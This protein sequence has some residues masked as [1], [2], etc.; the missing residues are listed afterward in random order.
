MKAITFNMFL[1]LFVAIVGASLSLYL[2]SQVVHAPIASY[3]QSTFTGCGRSGQDCCLN[4][5]CNVGLLCSNSICIENQS[6]TIMIDE[7][8]LIY[9]AS[10]TLNSTQRDEYLYGKAGLGLEDCSNGVNCISCSKIFNFTNSS[11]CLDCSLCDSHDK[12]CKD[13]LSCNSAENGNY[14]DLYECYNCNNCNNIQYD[15]ADSCSHCEYC[16]MAN[17]TNPSAPSNASFCSSCYQCEPGTSDKCYSCYDCDASKE[18]VCGVCDKSPQTTCKVQ[19]DYELCKELKKHIVSYYNEQTHEVEELLSIPWNEAYF[20]NTTIS[21]VLTNCITEDLKGMLPGN[22]QQK[23]CKYDSSKI[24]FIQNDTWLPVSVIIEPFSLGSVLVRSYFFNDVSYVPP[25]N[26]ANMLTLN[27]QY[28]SVTGENKGI[29]FN[30]CGVKTTPELI[31][32]FNWQPEI[33]YSSNPEIFSSSTAP[34]TPEGDIPVNLKIV[35]ADVSWNEQYDNGCSFNVYLCPQ[36]AIATSGDDTILNFYRFLAYFNESDYSVKTKT[37]NKVYKMGPLNDVLEVNVTGIKYPAFVVDLGGRNADVAHIAKALIAGFR[38]Y[39]A[40]NSDLNQTVKFF[41]EES[42]LNFEDCYKNSFSVVINDNVPWNLSSSLPADT[43]S[44]IPDYKYIFYDPAFTSYS[45]EV[46]VEL[47]FFA[48]TSNISYI[49]NT[50][51]VSPLIVLTPYHAP[52]SQLCRNNVTEGTEV[53]DGTDLGGQTCASKRYAGGTLAC[54]SDCTD[55]DTSGCILP[56]GPMQYWFQNPTT[57]TDLTKIQ[58]DV[59]YKT[60]YG[61]CVPDGWLQADGW[62]DGRCFQSSESQSGESHNVSAFITLLSSDP[63]AVI[64]NALADSSKIGVLECPNYR[65]PGPSEYCTTGACLKMGIVNTATQTGF[66]SIIIENMR[67]AWCTNPRGEVK[68]CLLCSDEDSDG[69]EGT[70]GRF[71]VCLGKDSSYPEYAP[72]AGI[73]VKGNN[74]SIGDHRGTW[75]CQNGK[76]YGPY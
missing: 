59:L 40:M 1:V 17:V 48:Y 2:Y 3:I 66:D 19:S 30:S 20:L 72:S 69:N 42:G 7:R 53:C 65:Y 9:N 14:G 71:Y 49:N 38:D 74:T 21:D 56:L 54:K 39:I 68:D 25:S 73:I 70:T 64:F 28:S 52:P 75:I 8:Y 23:I 58:S 29:L 50:I 76:W 63:N 36:E 32:I 4:N 10:E 37:F 46:Q 51:F 55:Y 31:K 34:K 16:S 43:L 67:T 11:N 22:I 27:G 57:Y 61:W 13:C 18:K 33:I 12:T 60:G 44:S 15:I 47:T 41:C 26:L 62:Y 35:V 45:N 24:N 5:W 6:L